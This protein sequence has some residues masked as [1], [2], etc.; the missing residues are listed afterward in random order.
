M[1][2]HIVVWSLAELSA[3]F[4]GELPIDGFSGPTGSIGCSCRSNLRV[5][6]IG[7]RLQILRN[8]G[9]TP[10]YRLLP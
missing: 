4:A 8:R 10:D 1:M 6:R 5:E 2:R 7:N 3:D 9:P